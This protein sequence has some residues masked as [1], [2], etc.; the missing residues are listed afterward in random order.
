MTGRMGVE[1]TG[2]MIEAM[3]AGVPVISTQVRTFPE[4]ITDGIN[5]FLVPMK[6]TRALAEAIRLLA[7]DPT[8]RKKMGQANR[9]KGQEFRA[10]VVVAQMLKIVFPEAVLTR[11]QK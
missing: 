9:L 7:V 6:D 4:L 3:H 8:L 2:V 5:G 10:D 1:Y 11:E